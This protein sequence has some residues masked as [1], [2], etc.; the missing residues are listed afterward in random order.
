MITR[1]DAQ[2]MDVLQ[3]GCCF[4]CGEPAGAKA[5]FDHVVPQAYGGVN[6]PGN[7]VLAHRR[8]NQLKGDRLPTP[9]EVERF[10]AQ[11]RGSRLGVWPPVAALKGIGDEDEAWIAVARAIAGLPRG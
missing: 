2:L 10:L 4:Y 5:T 3:G 11:R 6:E 9:E 8:C 7:V 1:D